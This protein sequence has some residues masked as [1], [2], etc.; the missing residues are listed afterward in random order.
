MQSELLDQLAQLESRA[1]VAPWGVVHLDD[2]FCMSM[3]AITNRQL[4][5]NHLYGGDWEGIHV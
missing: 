5:T 2:N 1:S 4:P 3:V